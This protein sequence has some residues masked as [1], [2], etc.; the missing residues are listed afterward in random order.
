MWEDT[1]I[2]GE[3]PK[4]LRDQGIRMITDKN[5]EITEN[6]GRSSIGKT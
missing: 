6:Y 1:I 5:I 3:K 4:E 2:G